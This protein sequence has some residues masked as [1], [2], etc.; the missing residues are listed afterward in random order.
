[1]RFSGKTAVITGGTSGIGLATALRLGSEGASL[2]LAGRHPARGAAAVATVEAVGAAV[3]YV[4]CDVSSEAEVD[5]LFH[6]AKTEFGSVDLAFL[7]AGIEGAVAPVA[8]YPVRSAE[9]VL[10]T[11]V[12]GIFLCTRATLPLLEASG[13]VLINTA[14]SKGVTAAAPQN[15]IYAA[16]KAAVAAFT[17]SVAAGLDAA[18]VRAYTLCPWVTDSPMLD[19][20]AVGS[21][22]VKAELAAANPGGRAVQPDDVAAVVA[23]LWSG[24]LD[25]PSGA[26]VLVG[27]GGEVTCVEHPAPI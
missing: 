8:E 3:R 13:G 20:L 15:A 16:S 23:D 18:G 26:S 12:K 2:V 27:A 10:A 11:N 9:D 4:C 7:N 24:A 22:A 1:M 6:R 21:P 19:R 14:S 5:A 17:A 25:L